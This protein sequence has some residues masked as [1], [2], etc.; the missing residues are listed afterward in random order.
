MA[1]AT[2]ERVDARNAFNATCNEIEGHLLRILSEWDGRKIWKTSGYGG[3]TAKFEP[4]LRSYQTSHGY[5]L[6][7]E[8]CRIWVNVRV[9]HGTQ[10]VAFVRD[11]H[12]A[13][14]AEMYLGR[15]TE[16][17]EVSSLNECRQRKT[18]YTLEGVV[19]TREKAYALECQARDLRRSIA[20]FD[21]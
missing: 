3:L 15:T 17:G 11:T 7:A 10:I 12:Q 1:Y 4:V 20:D 16:A 8:G 9:Q 14:S 21:R 18:D 5:N 19:R 6:T 2:C 13:L